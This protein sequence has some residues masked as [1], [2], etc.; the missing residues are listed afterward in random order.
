LVAASEAAL[1]AVSPQNKQAIRLGAVESISSFLLPAPLSAFRSRWPHV[2]VRIAIGLC[3]D[4]RGRVGRSE[5]D[6]AL[7]IEGAAKDAADL[8]PTHLRFVVAPTHALADRVVDRADLAHGTLLLTDHE[9]AF[10]ALLTAWLNGAGNAPRLE[11]AGSVDGVKRGVMN[12]GVI[13]VLPDYA[14]AQE[15]AD[16]ALV[17]LTLNVAPPPIALRLTTLKP[18]AAG[19]L[20]D[21]LIGEIR[22]AL[23]A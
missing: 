6:A 23:P 13:G 9:G 11:S 18:P 14:V 19:S 2:D 17:A 16:G 20:L 15:L 21:G 4:L 10:N 8:L 7:T 1:A 5:L 22:S 3:E 12:S